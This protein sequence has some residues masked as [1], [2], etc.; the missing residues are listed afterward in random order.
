MVYGRLAR[1]IRKL[2]LTGFAEYIE[3]LKSADSSEIGECVNA[4][5]TNL[6]AFYREA[7]H[8]EFLQQ[9]ALPQLMQEKAQSKRL[10]LWSA[11][12]SSGEEPYSLAMTVVETLPNQHNWNIK[13]LATDIDSHTLDKAKAGVYTE[14]RVGGISAKR[15]KRWFLQ[16]QGSHLGHV[17]VKPELS[18]MI[19]FKLLN[20]MEDWPIHGPLDVIFCRNVVI[21]FDKDTQ[22]RLFNHYADLLKPNGYLFI[23]HS[24]SLF[25]VTD[26]FQS[27]G[28]TIYQKIK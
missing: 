6:T 19:A 17:R 14:E 5:T 24:E 25:R 4:I 1:R 15:L 26:R 21:Y 7:H 2:A 9:T 28:R 11:G 3:L 27:L 16:G 20:L 12:C 23:G 18:A 22:R 10:R 13:I 8:F